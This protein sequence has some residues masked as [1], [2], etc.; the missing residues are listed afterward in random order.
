MEVLTIYLLVKPV[1]GGHPENE[2]QAAGSLR[3]MG[4]ASILFFF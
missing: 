2:R 4:F 3:R 1:F